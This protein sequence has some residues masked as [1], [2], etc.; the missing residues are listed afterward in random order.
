M[1]ATVRRSLRKSYVNTVQSAPAECTKL[2]EATSTTTAVTPFWCSENRSSS[3]LCTR[4]EATVS[5][6]E[7]V[8]KTSVIAG[9]ANRR[10]N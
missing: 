7:V 1:C 3:S 2:G 8:E 9:A 4:D 10:H 6:R 5:T